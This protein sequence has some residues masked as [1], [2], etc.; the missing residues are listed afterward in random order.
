MQEL[1]RRIVSNE[2]VLPNVMGRSSSQS[3]AFAT[4][5]NSTFLVSALDCG[6]NKQSQVRDGKGEREEAFGRGRTATK[7]FL[8]LYNAEEL[9]ADFREIRPITES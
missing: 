6:M 5:V 1:L 7:R 2:W 8:S 9:D 3:Q 4:A